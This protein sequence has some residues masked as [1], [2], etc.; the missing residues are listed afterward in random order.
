MSRRE[1]MQAMDMTTALSAERKEDERL[2]RFAS[3]G[4]GGSGN[5]STNGGRPR[6]IQVSQFV[7]SATHGR[8]K[9]S[10]INKDAASPMSSSAAAA[11]AAAATTRGPTAA[12]LKHA[13]GQMFDEMMGHCKRSGFFDDCDRGTTE[14]NLKIHHLTDTFEQWKVSGRHGSLLEYSG[15]SGIGSGGTIFQ[16][17]NGRIATTVTTPPR[18]ATSPHEGK[19]SP[20]TTSKSASPTTAEKSRNEMFQ[21]F[22]QHAR[23]RGFFNGCDK[24]TAAY[25][26]KVQQCIVKFEELRAKQGYPAQ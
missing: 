9:T 15:L 17:R 26:L 20:P 14:Y 23:S 13:D 19:I 2:Q 25:N 6:E 5:N 4:G 24:G 7:P 3:G 16:Q 21:A 11:A 8:I 18:R 1:L 12:E 10:P 22:L